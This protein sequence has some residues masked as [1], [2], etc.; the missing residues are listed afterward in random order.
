MS[1]EKI[2]KL[3]IRRDSEMMYYVKNGDVWA[4][5]RKVPGKPKSRAI[6]IA[7]TGIEMDYSNYLYYLDGDGDLARKPRAVGGTRRVHAADAELTAGLPTVRN[8]RSSADPLSVLDTNGPEAA[9]EHS[10]REQP[11]GDKEQGR[12]QHDAQHDHAQRYL[13]QQPDAWEQDELQNGETWAIE[14]DVVSLP[15]SL[16][17]AATSNGTEQRTEGRATFPDVACVLTRESHPDEHCLRVDDYARALAAVMQAA[18]GEFCFAIFG[19]WGRGKT[20]LMQRL[21][22]LLP[23]TTRAVWFSAWKYRTRPEIWIHLYETIARASREDGLWKSKPRA[24]RAFLVRHGVFPMLASL[25]ALAIAILGLGIVPVVVGAVG[26]LTLLKAYAFVRWARKLPPLLFS[27]PQHSDK[28]GMQATVGDDLIALLKGWMPG[29]KKGEQSSS[30]LPSKWWWL[31]YLLVVAFVTAVVYH[32]LRPGDHAVANLYPSAAVQWSVTVIFGLTGVLLPLWAVSAGR[33]PE[34]LVLIVDDLDRCDPGTMLELIESLKLFLEDPDVSSRV[35]VFM[36]VDEDAL[37]LAITNRYLDIRRL[38]TLDKLEDSELG[39]VSC[40]VTET[41]EKLFVAHLRLPPLEQHEL[42]EVMAAYAWQPALRAQLRQAQL[43]RISSE[44]VATDHNT[45]HPL[46][47]EEDDQN[48]DNSIG[49]QREL[50]LAALVFTAEERAL[51]CAA[52]RKMNP[53]LNSR[54]GPRTLRTFLLRYQLAKFLLARRGTSCSP[55]TLID[56]LLLP[57]ARLVDMPEVSAVVA[58]VS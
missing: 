1:G 23:S 6:K 38:G 7:S 26:L 57:N 5:R 31:P 48:N 18:R 37:R 49:A 35:Q 51:L 15:D 11:Q 58:Q 45:P 54:I 44:P 21:A 9:N 24:V 19:H 27:L 25:F 56:A 12:E 47:Q 52:V 36:L 2:A 17:E 20:F 13:A 32:A 16:G 34:R 40:A 29:G 28:L 33:S 4:V 30:G 8:R 3:G 39:R 46:G 50:D 43:V 14:A 22:A 53:Y 42:E 41:I 10:H 55:R